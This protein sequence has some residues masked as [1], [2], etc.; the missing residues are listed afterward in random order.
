MGV[1]FPPKVV[2]AVGVGTL[3]R[4][5]ASVG[6]TSGSLPPAPLSPSGG[7]VR[8]ASPP[9]GVDIPQQFTPPPPIP[10]TA[11]PTSPWSQSMQGPASPRCRLSRLRTR[12]PN[13][14]VADPPSLD[15]ISCLPPPP[16]STA[17]P[18]PR[19]G[20]GPPHATP[21]RSPHL[22]LLIRLWRIIATASGSVKTA[23]WTT[24]HRGHCRRR[25][26]TSDCWE[27]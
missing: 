24:P 7:G 8:F 5:R 9:R 2:G 18:L 6:V 19:P 17:N 13:P 4:R 11:D 25:R 10:K 27:F 22:L 23:C 15:L 3:T 21:R 14:C 26:E 12:R 1:S 20:C 16:Q